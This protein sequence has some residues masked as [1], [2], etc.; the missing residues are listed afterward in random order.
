MHF[1]DGTEKTCYKL[2][3]EEWFSDFWHW[4]IGEQVPF[5][6]INNYFRLL[7]YEDFIPFDFIPIG[8]SHE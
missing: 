8:M 3:G 6:H 7:F 4:Q 1:G 2:D 5:T